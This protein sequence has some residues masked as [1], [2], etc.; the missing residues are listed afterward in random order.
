MDDISAT[1][2]PAARSESLVEGN[3]AFAFDLYGRLKGKP[4]N[5]FF[6]P[7]SIST[8]LAAAYAGA[9]GET[10]MQMGR[11]LHFSKD[12][13]RV[14]SSFGEL[15]R[16]LEKMEKPAV[17]Q[18]RPGQ[19]G[20]RPSFLQVPGIQLNIAIS[21]WVQEGQPF[22]A[23]FLKIATD[24]Y[25]ADVNQAN[26]QTQPEAVTREINRWVAEKTND[27]IQNILPP[28]CVDIFTRLVLANAIYF[29]A[30][31]AVPFKKQGTSTNS[32]H[33]TASSQAEVFSCARQ[34]S[35]N[36]PRIKI[37]K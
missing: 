25:L 26:F 2:N 22:L 4:G 24:E 6:S 12:Q 1:S 8:C 10:E 5:L 7:F 16:Q 28:D 11:V 15:H 3:T 27:K 17:I 36:T 13:A 18:T 35:S 14:H 33:L 21:L 20:T 19:G 37:F 29:K 23:E 32:F 31:W 30:A 34:M 9:R